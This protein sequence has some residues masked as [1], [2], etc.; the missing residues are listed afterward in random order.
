MFRL[1][2][3]TIWVK[4]NFANA[5]LHNNMLCD[6]CKLFPCTQSH[7]L[8]CPK[9]T[10]TIVVD[11]KLKLNEN[12]LYGNVEQQLVYVKIFKLFWDLREKIVAEQSD[13][14]EI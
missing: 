8:H 12:Y 11:N 5:Y 6:L 2:S 13:D 7:I 1:R 9:L 14:E 10:T 3:K 4:E